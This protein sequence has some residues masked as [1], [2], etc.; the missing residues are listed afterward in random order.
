M[1]EIR[2]AK[3]TEH[4]LKKLL[5]FAYRSQLLCK[6]YFYEEINS[7]GK[8]KQTTRFSSE[9]EKKGISI[10]LPLVGNSENS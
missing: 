10:F 9:K 6:L 7:Q 2:L 3:G 5:P 8:E 1:L 4:E